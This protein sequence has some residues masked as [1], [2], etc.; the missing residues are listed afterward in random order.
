MQLSGGA[1]II[2]K[3]TELREAFKAW[4][5]TKGTTLATDPEKDATLIQAL[6]D[7]NIMLD[8]IVRGPFQGCPAFIKVRVPAVAGPQMLLFVVSPL[9]TLPMRSVS[10]AA[11]HCVPA[12]LVQ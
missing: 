8:Q 5:T 1:E 4:V 10:Y 2:D 3:S 9:V 6:I 7:L 11:Y 12:E